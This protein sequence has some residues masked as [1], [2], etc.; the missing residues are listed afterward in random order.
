MDKKEEGEISDDNED[1]FDLVYKPVSR[2]DASQYRHAPRHMP[3]SDEEYSSDSDSDAPSIP[4]RKRPN[5]S[6]METSAV[7]SHDPKGWTVG[8]GELEAR[9]IAKPKRRNNIWSTVMEEQVLS[10]EI[11][12][13]GL[14]RRLDQGD[15]SVES[16]DYS[17]AL[18]VHGIEP[19]NSDEEETEELKK[20]RMDRKRHVKERLNYR[21][22]K[23]EGSP[24]ELVDMS[25]EDDAMTDEEVGLA[26]AEGLHER[27]PELI[28]RVVEVL[29]REKALELYKETQKVEREGGLMILNGSRRRTS[30]GVYLQ[31]LKNVP[32]V[33]KAE[34]TKI[35]PQEESTQQWRK[36]KR[37]HRK[38]ER[39]ES[40][41]QGEDVSEEGL[42]LGGL[43]SDDPGGAKCPG[44]TPVTSPQPSDNE[45][46]DLAGSTINRLS[47]SALAAE[48]HSP[49]YDSMAPSENP[50][51]PAPPT[52]FDGK[53]ASGAATPTPV[54]PA[55]A[56]PPERATE[57]YDDD[58]LD[59]HGNADEMDLF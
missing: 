42:H 11:G 36:R 20:K 25:L 32:T 50:F 8:S 44:S 7:E 13:F 33:G 10:Q 35:F 28:V 49:H 6:K 1:S 16:Y 37:A 3:S 39:H 59:I 40:K 14:K 56:H 52:D 31:L 15:R 34:L 17:Q 46:E 23:M 26:I 24:R 19:E 5:I 45:E 41:P 4:K 58:F 18:R 51:A 47:P 54:P 21:K 43:F 57:V 12:G 2:P 30:G 55:A 38:R 48:P 9:R 22:P 29:G 53:Y 27:K